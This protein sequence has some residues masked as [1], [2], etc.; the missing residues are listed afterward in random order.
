MKVMFIFNLRSFIQAMISRNS[1]PLRPQ[2]L[3]RGIAIDIPVAGV[4]VQSG[5]GSGGVGG[6][7][8]VKLV[9]GD[10]RIVWQ[11]GTRYVSLSDLFIN[12]KI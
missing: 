3:F 8:V 9:Q 1:P 7:L 5:V 12:V 11:D 4:V 10:G 6:Q 2:E